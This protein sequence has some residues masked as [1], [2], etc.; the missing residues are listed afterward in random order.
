MTIIIV[1]YYNTIIV[2]NYNNGHIII[3]YD[4][5]IVL[6]YRMKETVC[7]KRQLIMPYTDTVY[8]IFIS[9]SLITGTGNHSFMQSQQRPIHPSFGW[10]KI[11][12]D[13]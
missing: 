9:R 12:V 10:V 5:Y 11:I 2:W 1:P 3:V 8:A 13:R 4:I 7:A 6:Y